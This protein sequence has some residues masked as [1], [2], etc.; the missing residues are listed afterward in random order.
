MT[1]KNDLAEYLFHQGTNYY[2]YDFLGCTTKKLN[3]E[4][5]YTFRVWAPNA[6]AVGLL[7]DYNGW[8]DPIK[9]NKRDSS[10]WECTIYSKQSLDGCSYKFAISNHGKTILKGDPYAKFSKGGADG[11]SIIFN[12]KNFVWND[13]AWINQK[14]KKLNSG[15]NILNEPL[16]IYEVHLGS[17]ARHKEDN[18][19]LSY[20]EICDILLPYVKH[21]GFTHVEFLPIAE[22]PFDGSWGYQVG[23]FYA[24]TSRFGTPDDFRYLVNKF[25]CN[26]IGVIL[27]WVPA[28]FPK[29]EWGLYE[30]DGQPL[31]EYQG[32]DRQE[33]ASWGTRF[34]DLGR[35]EVQSFLISNAL[36]FLREFHIDGLRVDAVASMLYLDYDRDPAFWI[37]NHYGGKENLEAIAF[38]KK[39][40][41][42]IINEFPQALMIAEESGDYGRITT[43][44]TEGGLG[45]TLKWNMGWANDFYDYI[46]TDPFFR[47]EK[48][49][50]L[51]FPIMYAF[52]EKY[53]LPISHDEVVHGKFSFINKMH[54]NYEDKFSQMRT[55]LMFMMT[56]PGKKLMFMGTEFAQFR[57]WDYENSLEWFMLDYPNH[58]AML[59]YVS[60]LNNFYLKNS[61][62]WTYDFT[63]SGFEWIIVD[64]PE[65]NLIAY[66]RKSDDDELIIVINF[67]GVSQSTSFE[68]STSEPLC[69][70]FSTDNSNNVQKEIYFEADTKKIAITTPAFS[71]RIYQRQKKENKFKL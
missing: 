44:I 25:H 56:F 65:K 55:A 21:M 12:S 58:T 69:C 11:A 34:F 22:H 7:S 10:I 3:D 53:V 24:T 27:D 60:S 61:S 64:E 54:G 8:N 47:K 15:I 70:V 39:L 42:A 48:H 43:P 49:S 6:Q 59:Q 67:S 14:K 32:H 16:N 33:S 4:F 28:H 17:F 57:E 26:G 45:F 30:F 41:S 36:Y 9:M 46:M 13:S 50:A 5:E 2:S 19:F 1:K 23:A 51:T 20:R 62:L 40:N 38:L 68:I 52:K 35:E 66:K 37:P 29:D 63:D 71:G 18:S 31:Y